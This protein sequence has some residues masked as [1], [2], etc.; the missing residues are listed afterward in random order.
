MSP[1]G[2]GRGL[3]A[4]LGDTPDQPESGVMLRL[5]SIEPN[6]DQPRKNFD[7]KPL[8]ELADSIRENGLIQPLVVRPIEDGRYMLIAG[9]R[10]WRACRM[11]GPPLFWKRTTC[12]QHS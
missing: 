1:K 11:A 12:G 5:S 7:P 6:P 4:L 2:L 9:E 8:Q 3:S 10:R